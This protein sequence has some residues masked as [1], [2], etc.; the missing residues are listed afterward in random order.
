MILSCCINR[1]LE[2][3]L[4]CIGCGQ[5]HDRVLRKTDFREQSSGHLHPQ[6]TRDGQRKL[7]GGHPQ[8]AQVVPWQWVTTFKV[9][10]PP[11]Y[12]PPP[13]HPPHPPPTH[14][15]TH[16]RTTPEPLLTPMHRE[17]QSCTGHITA[18]RGVAVYMDYDMSIHPNSF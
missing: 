2:L 10:V 3:Q 6:N 12:H 8:K 1:G 4:P 16:S 17:C 13:P 18:R 7:K 11:P 9:R 15:H 14:T 5:T